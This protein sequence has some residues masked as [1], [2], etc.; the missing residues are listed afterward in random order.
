M[1]GLCPTATE[2]TS[3]KYAQVKLGH[4]P[5]RALRSRVER[6][7]RIG[8]ALLVLFAGVSLS[9][10]GVQPPAREVFEVASIKLNKDGGSLAGLRRIPGGRFEATNIQLA[11]LIAFAHQL[12]PF[13]LLGGPAWLT[14]D[15][16][17]VLAKIDGDP[18]RLPPGDP[19]PD[20]MMLATRALLADRF[21]LS[22]HRD[23]QDLEVYRLV[24]A[25]DDRRFGPGLR[26]STYDCAG[27]VRAQDEAAKGGPAAPD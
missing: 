7:M 22:M 12:Q 21:K 4:R 14:T 18:P 15:R 5:N 25:R 11:A 27:L 3:R 24:M 16:W 20:A 23:T 2:L 26:Q 6:T 1:V 9:A 8:T 19:R 17:D 13:E 10:Q